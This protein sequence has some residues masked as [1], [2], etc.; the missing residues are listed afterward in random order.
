MHLSGLRGDMGKPLLRAVPVLGSCQVSALRVLPKA[1]LVPATTGEPGNHRTRPEVSGPRRQCGGTTGK[2]V[3]KMGIPAWLGV[4][5]RVLDFLGT[6]AM[7]I[8][9]NSKPGSITPPVQCGQCGATPWVVRW[10]AIRVGQELAGFYY[11]ATTD[12]APLLLCQ[13]CW[14]ESLG[15]TAPRARAGQGAESAS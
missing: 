4:A 9:A 12:G 5:L 6:V 14:D 2:G 1:L 11:Q 15:N 13:E 3:S 7:D 8:D 10:G